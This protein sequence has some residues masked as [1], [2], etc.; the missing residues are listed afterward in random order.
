MCDG[1]ILN[2][3]KH[4]TASPPQA[5]DLSQLPAWLTETN[6]V[7]LGNAPS[8]D[9]KHFATRGIQPDLLYHK[10]THSSQ[11]LC[12]GISAVLV[13]QLLYSAQVYCMHHFII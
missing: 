2:E 3:A 9:C 4:L 1:A 5:L 8:H 11:T 6:S 10:T 7:D 12:H 13:C